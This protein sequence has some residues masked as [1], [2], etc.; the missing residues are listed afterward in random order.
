MRVGDRYELAA[1]LAGRYGKGS[2]QE[3]G[4]I[5]DA[6]CLATGY[7]RKY[8]IAVLRGRRQVAVRR[9]TV[10]RFGRVIWPHFGVKRQ[11]YLA[12]PRAPQPYLPDHW[13][14]VTEMR[15]ARQG[16]AV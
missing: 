2:R 15:S 5:L 13:S 10:R 14:G 12:P 3:R 8:A 1:E 9:R 11:S 6:Y 7:H 16:G 4:A